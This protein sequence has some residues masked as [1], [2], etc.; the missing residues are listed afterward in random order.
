MFRFHVFQKPEMQSN[1]ST[2]MLIK[3]KEEIKLEDL[4][5]AE[6]IFLYDDS[7]VDSS[8]PLDYEA[9]NIVGHFSADEDPLSLNENLKADT[10]EV[11]IAKPLRKTGNSRYVLFSENLIFPFST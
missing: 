9:C 7:F 1:E 6:D 11:L 8:N 10:E 5:V 4:D 3:I 2:S